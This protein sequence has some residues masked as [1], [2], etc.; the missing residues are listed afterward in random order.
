MLV[1]ELTE[2]VIGACIEVH[3]ETGSGLL[4]STYRRCLCREL[5]LRG[6]PFLCEVPLPIHY[7]GELIDCGYS[8]DL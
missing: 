4:E 1:N 8:I 5:T 6:I 2:V 3:K 7:K